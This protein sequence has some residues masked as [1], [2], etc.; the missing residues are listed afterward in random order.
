MEDSNG[1][2]Q[3]WSE[4]I[5]YIKKMREFY[6]GWNY[7]ELDL[8]PIMSSEIYDGYINKKMGNIWGKLMLFKFLFTL[9]KFKVKGEREK[10]FVS[11]LMGRKDHRELVKKAIEAF[12]KNSLTILDAYEYKKN[13]LPF[14]FKFLFPDFILLLKIWKKFKNKSIKD[15]LKGDWIYFLMR[16][17]FRCKQIEQM[18]S[19]YHK[20]LPRAYISFCSSAFSEEAIF[21]LICKKNKIPTFTLQH[22]F[23]SNYSSNFTTFII[24]SENIISDYLLLWGKS[25]YDIQKKF[26]DKSRLIVVGNPKYSHPRKTSKK[27]NPRE[28]TV[29]FSVTGYEESNK[30]MLKILNG[31]ALKHSEIKF[32]LKLH[33]FDNV[34]NYVKFITA[35]NIKFVHKEIPIKDLLEISDFVVVHNTSI[36]Y[37]AL[38]YK[39]PVFRFKDKFF[40]NIWK[41]KDTFRN[42]K[43][44]ENLYLKFRKSSFLRGSLK[45]YDKKMKEFFYFH[46]KKEPSQIYYE[47]I[48]DKIN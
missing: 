32:K 46:P 10:I 9:D 11:Y 2:L 22:G 14:K 5:P 43:E 41:N 24:Q 16:T 38:L 12:P 18:Y 48:I 35:K 6:S 26:I 40:A 44:L 34:K 17:Y 21:T 19:I 42:F 29:F 45:F 30:K 7:K 13:I 20:Y 28:V 4:K 3:L 25:S 33:P 1:N 8:W 37:E 15:N 23:L 39:I 36:A 27:F 47:K 31:F